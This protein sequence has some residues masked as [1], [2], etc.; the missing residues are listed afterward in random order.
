MSKRRAARPAVQPCR[1]CGDLAQATVHFDSDWWESA[2]VAAEQRMA[3][4]RAE[5]AE[6]NKHLRM[7]AS[8]R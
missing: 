6:A 4:A 7:L 1:L 2:K 8:E 3:E 5:I